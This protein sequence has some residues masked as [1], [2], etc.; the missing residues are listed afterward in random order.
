MLPLNTSFTFCFQK[1]FAEGDVRQ[2]VRLHLK[3]IHQTSL[4]RVTWLI[5]KF[6]KGPH[7]NNIS[8]IFGMKKWNCENHCIVTNYKEKID[9]KVYYRP[10]IDL[11]SQ[12]A[13][14][15]YHYWCGVGWVGDQEVFAGPLHHQGRQLLPRRLPCSRQTNWL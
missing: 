6:Y 12:I 8:N 11:F 3:G 15:V 7:K 9:W 5:Q 4:Q 13:L 10:T 2:M 14:I 1:C